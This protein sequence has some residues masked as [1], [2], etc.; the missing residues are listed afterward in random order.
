VLEAKHKQVFISAE[1]E[2][3]VV[4]QRLIFPDLVSGSEKSVKA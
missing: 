4:E 1:A 2:R 3:A